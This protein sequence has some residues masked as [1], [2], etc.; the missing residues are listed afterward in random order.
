M[1]YY[2]SLVYEDMI[3]RRK[4][5]MGGSFKCIGT[6]YLNVDTNVFKEH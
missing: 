4:L 2:Y 1:L 5:H 3:A 6:C